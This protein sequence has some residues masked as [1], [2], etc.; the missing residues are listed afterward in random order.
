MTYTVQ[1]T[2]GGPTSRW[3]EGEWIISSMLI[4]RAERF[5]DEIAV[6]SRRGDVTWV[7]L[8]ER[9][10]RVAGF[11][12]HIGIEPGDRVATLLPSTID[13]MAAWHGINWRNAIDVPV[14]NEY[15]GAFLEHQ[16]RDSGARAIVIDGRWVDRLNHIELSPALEHVIVWGEPEADHPAGL[17]LHDFAGA[18]ASDPGS[19][20]P[21]TIHDLTYIMLRAIELMKLRDPNLNAR[22]YS[23]VNSKDYLE[24]LCLANIITGSTPALHNDK[25]A[26]KALISKGETEEQARDYGVVGCVEPSSA[27][28]HYGHCGA[29]LLNLPSASK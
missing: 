25:A 16:L 19:L 22:Y 15:K 13:Y 4:D 5:G 29:V 1:R 12:E 21:R 24:R 26:I 10:A 17:A 20:V 23:G 18:L 9:A 11:L 14:N 7:G 3:Y 2:V 8:V 28:R 6:Y 27:G